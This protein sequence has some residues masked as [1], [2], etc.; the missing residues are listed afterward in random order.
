[1]K[2]ETPKPGDT[3]AWSI[4]PRTNRTTRTIRDPA[5]WHALGEFIESFASTET[6]LFTYLGLHAEIDFRIAIALLEV[7]PEKETVG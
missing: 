7:D 4:D 1:M 2:G 3:I 6:M 5:Y